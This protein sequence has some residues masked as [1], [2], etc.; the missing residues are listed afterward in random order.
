MK[1]VISI[2]ICKKGHNIRYKDCGVDIQDDFRFQRLYAT[3]GEN[4]PSLGAEDPR[5]GV[6]C[7]LYKISKTK[8]LRLNIKIQ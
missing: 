4:N 6:L 7:E 5:S 2:A 8:Y 3:L 1:E